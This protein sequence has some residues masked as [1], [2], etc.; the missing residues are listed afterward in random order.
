MHP[1]E[2]FIR[3]MPEPV[4]R[5]LRTDSY[6]SI[7]LNS[8]LLCLI[9]RLTQHHLSV[10]CYS[11]AWSYWRRLGPLV[12]RGHLSTGA[13]TH[14]QLLDG[15]PVGHRQRVNTEEEMQR[16]DA[17]AEHDGPHHLPP[18]DTAETARSAESR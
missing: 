7:H 12:V 18:R 10:V 17:A 1:L 3:N 16:Q 5:T 8:P 4:T 9:S 11:P 6:K 15:P 14:L 2:V 13:V